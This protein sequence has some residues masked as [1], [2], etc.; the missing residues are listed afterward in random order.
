MECPVCGMPN[1][2]T[3]EFCIACGYKL[4]FARTDSRAD[5]ETALPQNDELDDLLAMPELEEL[6]KMLYS[7]LFEEEY[8]TVGEEKL[9]EV[10]EPRKESVYDDEVET[11]EEPEP[12]EPSEI[13]APSYKEEIEKP[14]PEK[15]AATKPPAPA[16]SAMPVRKQASVEKRTSWKEVTIDAKIPDLPK[17]EEFKPIVVSEPPKALSFKDKRKKPP[18]KTPGKQKPVPVPVPAKKQEKRREKESVTSAASQALH[19]GRYQVEKILSM[20]QNGRTL[21]AKDTSQYK[22][23]VIKEITPEFGSPGDRA[24]FKKRFDMEAQNLM[25]LN[26]LYLPRV[27]D[28]FAEGDSFYLVSLYIAGENLEACAARHTFHRVQVK[29]AMEWMKKVLLILSYLHKQHK[30]V[31]HKNIKPENIILSDKGGIYLVGFSVIGSPGRIV[32][33]KMEPSGF[34]S[35][36]NFAGEYNTGTDIY[37]LG[38]VIHYLLSGEHPNK[39][40]NFNFPLLSHYRRDVPSS[41]DRLIMKMV[42]NVP[43]HRYRRVEDITKYLQRMDQDRGSGQKTESGYD[44]PSHAPMKREDFYPPMVEYKPKSP[45]KQEPTPYRPHSPATEKTPA[46]PVAGANLPPPPDMSTEQK[47]G[48]SKGCCSC[49][50]IIIAFIILLMILSSLSKKSKSPISTYRKS[51]KKIAG[52]YS[53]FASW[54]PVNN[55]GGFSRGVNAVSYSRNGRYLAAG[56]GDESVYLW[57]RKKAGKKQIIS[58]KWGSVNSVAFSP[59]CLLLAAGC[60]NK[61]GIWDP[62]KG[63]LLLSLDAHEGMVSSVAFSP[64]NLILASAGRDGAVKL[65]DLRKKKIVA[66]ELLAHSGWVHSVAFSPDGKYLA[67]AGEDKVV[68]IWE[69]PTGKLSLRLVGHTGPVLAAAFTPDGKKAVSGG[70]DGTVRIWDPMTGENEKTLENNVRW[71]YSISCSPGNRYLAAGTRRVSPTAATPPVDA[72]NIWGIEKGELMGSLEGHKGEIWSLDFYPGG[73]Y[74]VSGSE[75]KAIRVWGAMKPK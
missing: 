21:L 32:D 62:D 23:V 55:M 3:D 66:Q 67:S 49:M 47:Q 40:K 5:E 51:A 6:D 60:L 74:L 75:D 16:V 35:V 58:P 17:L 14:A 34:S 8:E 25:S 68:C 53:P 11:V 22:R 37:S 19:G 4:S 72:V 7:P 1:S 15:P 27:V 42:Q 71:V 36:E 45:V 44:E 30:T 24:Y 61:L 65:W 54:R 12:V 64:D 2:N 59:N 33:G 9:Y 39:R 38:A 26:H 41:I 63:K 20:G 57:D 73:N 69:V 50:V 46:P 70:A 13:K 10:E 48:S 52:S 31:I 18:V 29:E 43:E 56:C 28:Y